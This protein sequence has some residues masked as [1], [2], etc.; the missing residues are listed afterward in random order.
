[1]KKIVL[2]LGIF[3]QTLSLYAKKST[4]IKILAQKPSFI[5]LELKI[6]EIQQKWVNTPRGKMQV[7]SF[8]GCSNLQQE[9]A[10]NLPI[11]SKSITIP[12]NA[13][14]TYEVLDVDYVEY[15][16]IEIAP[17]KGKIT[18]KTDPATIPYT[19]GKIYE[20]DEL[21]P[22]ESV[23]LM[24]PHVF[25]DFR[26]QCIQFAPFQYNAINKTL[27]VSSRIKVKISFESGAPIQI[28]KPAV[29]VDEFEG[30]YKN[31]FLNYEKP[32]VRYSPIK[33]VG[34]LLVVSP[35]IFLNAIKPF[36]KWKEMK[37]IKTYLVN[38]DTITGGVTEANIIALAKYYYQTHNIA[39]M[40]IVGDNTNIPPRDNDGNDAF[41]YGPSDMGYAYI[42]NNDHYPEFIVGRFSGNTVAEIET[43]INRTL[44]YEKTPNVNGNWKST[45]IGI[46][47]SQGASIGDDNQIDYEHIH[48]IVDSNKNQYNYLTNVELYDGIQAQGGTDLPGSPNSSMFLNAINGGCSLINYAGHGASD[49]IVTCAFTNND[50]PSISNANQLPFFLTVGC[51]PG[52]FV[53]QTSFSE[54]I[55]RHGG[56]NPKGVISCFMSTVDQWW[57]SPMEAQDEF[58]AIMRG[59]RPSNLRNRLGALC[60]NGT[61]AMMD[62]YDTFADPLGGSEMTDTWVFF[63][64]PTVSL[65]NK[66]EGA[67]TTTHTTLMEQG[68]TS[69]QVNCPVEGATIGLYYQDKYLSSGIVSGGSVNLSF[70]AISGIDTVYVTA[71]KQNYVPSFSTI[72]TVDWPFSVSDV[73]IE[74]LVEVYPNPASTRVEVRIANYKKDA[75]SKISIFNT[76]SQKVIE[77]SMN[78]G[79]QSIDVSQLPRGMYHLRFNNTS[80]K[81]V[82]E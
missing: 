14:S 12:E 38:A 7:F 59:A 40:Q 8:E 18:R 66:N 37:G 71:T 1:M 42:S 55:I 61:M 21:Y 67:L 74:N 29:V 47:S 36:V 6:G 65:F 26:G 17:S 58:N 77:E 53:N 23:Y 52:N 46:G 19:F 51:Q 25:R 13:S 9:G 50:V 62:K 73:N 41:T 24:Q 75:G 81:I 16:N 45:Q 63:G 79:K 48:D 76:L 44:A 60:V 78:S 27:L 57:D 32:L 30:M 34:S 54:L 49:G 10:P 70:P 56:V 11:F 33:E 5:L 31:H 20:T 64:D 68:Q 43:Q 28:T 39:Y 4:E 15:Q 80:K 2:V 82:L 22:L 3:I 72:Y 69:L 35:G